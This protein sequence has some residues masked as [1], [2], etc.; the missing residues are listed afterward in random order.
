MRTLD[1]LEKGMSKAD[2]IQHMKDYKLAGQGKGFIFVTEQEAEPQLQDRVEFLN[3]THTEEGW[4]DSDWGFIYF[5][6][7]KLY[8]TGF[9]HD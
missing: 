7:N 1:E 5:I 6:D 2:V 3:F 4:G 8:R 9:S